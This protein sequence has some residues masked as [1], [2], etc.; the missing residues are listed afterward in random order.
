MS[1]QQ[2]NVDSLAIKSANSTAKFEVY[3][4]YL[5]YNYSLWM[6]QY[7]DNLNAMYG[8]LSIGDFE[9]VNTQ[10]HMSYYP[11]VRENAAGWRETGYT[12]LRN[13]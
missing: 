1:K 3:G 11:G 7:K 10:E 9:M 2:Y 4:L 6:N 8:A 13:F 12:D 5:K